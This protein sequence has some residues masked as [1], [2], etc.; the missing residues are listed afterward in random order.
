MYYL[1]TRLDFQ[2]WTFMSLTY[3]F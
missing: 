2:Q 1:F 3:R